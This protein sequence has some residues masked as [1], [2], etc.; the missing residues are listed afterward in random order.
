MI[1]WLSG[2]LLIVAMLVLIGLWRGESRRHGAGRGWAVA[3]PVTAVSLAALGYGFFGYNAQTGPWLSQEH[4]YRQVARDIIAG[5]TPSQAAAEVPVGALVRVLQRELARH[6]SAMGWYAL[7]TLYDQLGAPAQSE[8][9]ARKALTL[10]PE[11]PA[12]HLL[13]ARA[14]VRQARGALTDD[15][16]AQIDWVLSRQ[17][18]HDG[19]WMLLAMSADRAGR[20]PLAVQAWTALLRRHGHG[21]TADLLRKGLQH[22][23]DQLAAQQRFMGLRARVTAAGEGTGGTLF[24]FLRQKGATGQPLAAKRVVVREFPVTV[25]LQPS[26]WLQAYPAADV[27]LV[28]GARY[29]PAPGA[30]VDQAGQVAPSRAV[31]LPQKQPLQLEL[32][33]SGPGFRH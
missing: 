3:I 20:Y 33:S 11:E 23:R 5:Q 28:M 30:T 21:E 10:A 24:V 18:D 22:S 7:G 27:P 14:L 2:G 25:T 17:P 31:N 8:Q 26:D 15:A 12:M 1:W 6:P 29:T 16:K 13:L 19:A 32:G 4:Q 9:A